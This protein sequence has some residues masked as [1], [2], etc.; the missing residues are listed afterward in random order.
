[1]RLPSAL[2]LFAVPV[3]VVAC[4]NDSEQLAKT[5]QA[6]VS[7]IDA[8]LEAS[9]RYPSPP[10]AEEETYFDAHRVFSRVISFRLPTEARVTRGS[11]GFGRASLTLS[12]GGSEID[13]CFYVSG[14]A[15]SRELDIFV[16]L[17]N[18]RVASDTTQ[19]IFERCNSGASAQQIIQADEVTF[20]IESGDAS[21]GPTAAQLFINESPENC[22]PIGFLAAPPLDPTRPTKFIDLVRHVYQGTSPVQV[23]V[24]P[25]AIPDDQAAAIRGRVLDVDGTPLEQAHISVIDRP[26]FGT[27]WSRG[28]GA[29]DMVV[30]GGGEITLEIQWSGRLP[31]RR[32]VAVPIGRLAISARDGSELVVVPIAAD[33]CMGWGAGLGANSSTVRERKT[34][35][36]RVAARCTSRATCR[37]RPFARPRRRRR[38]AREGPGSPRCAWR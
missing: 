33:T 32:R 36:A 16:P 35:M 34:S 21:A 29:F 6:T 19:Y 18:L 12:L 8:T 37:R 27:T 5:S 25:G 10:A 28:D 4:A 38:S 9:R 11:A 15:A 3:F 26:E 31:V 24:V 20:R 17:K 2:R 1:M 7:C 22:Q 30:R 14:A 23:G 13:R